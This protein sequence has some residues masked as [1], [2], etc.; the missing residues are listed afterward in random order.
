[1]YPFRAADE[2][3]KLEFLRF[4]DADVKAVRAKYAP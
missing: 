1:M 4:T 3:E 2:G